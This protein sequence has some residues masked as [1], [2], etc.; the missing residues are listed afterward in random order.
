M[1]EY[2]GLR[3]VFAVHR[4][5]TGS[6]MMRD[7]G[8]IDSAVGRPRATAFGEDAYPSVWEKA[9]ALMHS[10]ARN[11]GFVDGNKRTAWVSAMTF[12]TV[13]GHPLDPAFD[14]GA[15]EK[16]VLAVA[17]GALTDVACIASELVQFTCTSG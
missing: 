6:I 4:A 16:F 2:L 10:L 9:A 12:L 11:H 13:N 1:T 5:I 14:V 3:H 7:P 17:T 8:A 15:A